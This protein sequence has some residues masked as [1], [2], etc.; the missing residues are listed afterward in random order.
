MSRNGKLTKETKQAKFGAERKTEAR[1]RCLAS[2]HTPKRGKGRARESTRAKWAQT[3]SKKG[4]QKKSHQ[5]VKRT[6][7]TFPAPLLVVVDASNLF[8]FVSFAFSFCFFCFLSFFV[9]VISFV[10]HPMDCIEAPV[11]CVCAV[12]VRVREGTN[13]GWRG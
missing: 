6:L 13:G 7:E 4:A 8:L 3:R 9:V 2:Q 1:L 12:V 11:L 10:L 5:L